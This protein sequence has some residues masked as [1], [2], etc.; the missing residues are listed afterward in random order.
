ML[1]AVSKRPIFPVI[2]LLF[3]LGAMELWRPFHATA[4]D[5]AWSALHYLQLFL[6]FLLFIAVIKGW[7]KIAGQFLGR[8]PVN[9]ELL[10]REWSGFF[11][12]WRNLVLGSITM[13]L[14]TGALLLGRTTDLGPNFL[15]ETFNGALL[16][17][18]AIGLVAQ[19]LIKEPKRSL[20]SSIPSRVLKL[21]FGMIL[22]FR[23]FDAAFPQRHGDPLYYNM[24]A[25]EVWADQGKFVEPQRLPL[26]N[27]ASSWEMLYVWPSALV[28]GT[29]TL[30]LVEAHVLSQ[31]THMWMG[32]AG[33]LGGLMII[34]LIAGFEP[35]MAL[36]LAGT[37]WCSSAL[38]WTSTMAK[39]D[40]G[41]SAL[42]FAGGAFLLI[43]LQHG[44]RW[45]FLGGLAWG[46]A[47]MGKYTVVFAIVALALFW[48]IYAFQKRRAGF[49]LNSFFL[50][51]AGLVGFCLG[52]SV[53]LV[54]NIKFAH[55]NPL[56]PVP[57]FG[58]PQE[59]DWPTFFNFIGAFSR[60]QLAWDTVTNVA[61]LQQIA[62]DHI[63]LSICLIL[64][65]LA[66]VRLTFSAAARER[67]AGVLRLET[68]VQTSLWL[69][70]CVAFG[71][72]LFLM[73]SGPRSDLRLFGPGV[74]LF[75]AAFAGLGMQLYGAI[76]G[77][78]FAFW[79]IGALTLADSHL[80]TQRPLEWLSAVG[81]RAEVASPRASL[82]AHSNGHVKSWLR[83]NI[84]LGSRLLTTGDNEFYYLTGY[85]ASSIPDDPI[86]DRYF[87]G[88]DASDPLQA[89]LYVLDFVDANG[90][91]YPRSSQVLKYVEARRGRLI[92]QD[93]LN[94]VWIIQEKLSFLR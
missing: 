85:D 41:V 67:L 51:P 50:V 78:S 84:P 9:A 52:A 89:P 15:P 37:S 43:A 62:R 80:L 88:V 87:A 12:H 25:A 27:Q 47:F 38:W 66:I 76:G 71:F 63:T 74:F 49:I 33:V 70:A 57:Q 7:G 75:V 24:I 56:F 64:L 26:V 34:L 79:F 1:T 68:R 29:E 53:F 94:T 86:W 44:G 48:V 59:S 73:K 83:A 45:M 42:V 92:H 20:F 13:M 77:R 91:L 69:A 60:K 30:G 8:Y 61:K 28:G 40:Y 10:P 2:K 11:L 21:I 82:L 16:W 6:R 90:S 35:R 93:G 81:G 14:I 4:V 46:L 36:A 31:W 32:L 65:L 39:N 72:L 17:I 23:F 58:F 3:A 18:A 5:S 55:G 19:A 54:R 22:F